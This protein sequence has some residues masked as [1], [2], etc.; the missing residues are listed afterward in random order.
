ME[1]AAPFVLIGPC[2]CVNDLVNYALIGDVAP[3]QQFQADYA[4]LNI[5][6]AKK[7]SGKK[8]WNGK[9]IRVYP[10]VVIGCAPELPKCGKIVA[11][12]VHTAEERSKAIGRNDSGD[13]IIVV[14]SRVPSVHR[15]AEKHAIGVDFANQECASMTAS[16]RR[17]ACVGERP[18]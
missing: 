6:G 4:C 2:H 14:E 18:R 17:F 3:I 15:I 11:M 13:L 8:N 12:D 9:R 7:R 5:V 16:I 1:S 10:Q